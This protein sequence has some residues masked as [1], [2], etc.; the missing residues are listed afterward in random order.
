MVNTNF[1]NVESIWISI[2]LVLVV[3][4]CVLDDSANLLHPVLVDRNKF[5]LLGVVE[6]FSNRRSETA[7]V[8]HG[9]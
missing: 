3:L 9:N 4:S 7:S 2:T 5:I 1:A 8:R 6:I